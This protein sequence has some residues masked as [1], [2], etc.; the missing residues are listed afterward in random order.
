MKKLLPLLA[1]ISLSFNVFAAHTWHDVYASSG[2]W[3]ARAA[4]ISAYQG[5]YIVDAD[6]RNQGQ[7]FN[8]DVSDSNSATFGFGFDMDTSDFDVAFSLTLYENGNN[9]TSK[10]CI[11]TITAKGPAIPDITVNNYNG[12]TCEVRKGARGR[13]FYVG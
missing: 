6:G 9:F 7:L 2:Q 10:A 11:F 12:A 5:G 3:N 1:C 4:I 13:D 8:F